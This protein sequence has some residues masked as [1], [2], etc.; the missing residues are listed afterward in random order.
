MVKWNKMREVAFK[1]PKYIHLRMMLTS[2]T[3]EDYYNLY[4]TLVHGAK[5]EKL[6]YLL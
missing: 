1:Y 6:H 5:S 2:I 3:H 4:H